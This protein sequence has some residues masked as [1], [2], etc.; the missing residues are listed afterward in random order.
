MANERMNNGVICFSLSQTL[1][2]LRSFC[3]YCSV[4][5]LMVYFLHV[6]FFVGCMVYDQVRLVITSPPVAVIIVVVD[7]MVVQGGPCPRICGLG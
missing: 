5:I 3:M 6:T 2:A 7:V 1:P 4:G